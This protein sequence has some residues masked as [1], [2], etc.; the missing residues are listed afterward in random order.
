MTTME[1]RRWVSLD[2]NASLI[3][4]KISVLLAG[5]SCVASIADAVRFIVMSIA[6]ALSAYAVVVVITP[7]QSEIRIVPLVSSLLSALVL[8]HR[9]RNFARSDRHRLG[10]VSLFAQHCVC[11]AGLTYLGLGIIATGFD[12]AYHSS[13]GE[14]NAL[15]VAC[16]ICLVVALVCVWVVHQLRLRYV[17]RIREVREARYRAE[18][19]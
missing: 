14:Q 13:N 8:L 19:D 4:P 18:Q 2:S 16:L 15:I 3:L 9:R 11:L 6:T 5:I 1:C 17:K 10:V 12:W 7:T